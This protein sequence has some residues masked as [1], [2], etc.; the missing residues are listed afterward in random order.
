MDKKYQI[1]MNDVKY[2]IARQIYPPDKALPTEAALIKQYGFSKVTVQ[3]AMRELVREGLIY[4][5]VGKGTFVKSDPAAGAGKLPHFFVVLS[6]KDSEMF[7]LLQGIEEVMVK[8]KC[9]FSFFFVN[10]MDGENDDLAANLDAFLLRLSNLEPQ[11]IICYPPNSVDGL[12]GYQ[13]ITGKKIPLILL[14]KEFRQYPVNCVV[15]D[16]YLGMYRLTRHLID[17][18]HTKIG[19]LSFAVSF[20]DTVEK[21]REGFLQCMRDSGMIHSESQ[22]HARSHTVEDIPAALDAL[23]ADNPGLTAV[24]CANDIIA[25]ICYPL[26]QR[27]GLRIPEDISVCAFDGYDDGQKLNP[28]LTAMRQ[29]LFEMGQYAAQAMIDTWH[30]MKGGIHIHYTFRHTIQAKLIENQSVKEI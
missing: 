21:R 3:K 20:G 4:R 8:N 10:N 22:I 5:V 18:G 1:V 13:E 2:N 15:S 14:D 24:V 19:Y 25:A 29:D 16:N 23:L 6:F 28:P 12:R 9:L 26:L 17:M 27:K 11:G 30:R 7:K